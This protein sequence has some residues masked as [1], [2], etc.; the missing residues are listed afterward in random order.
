M[1]RNYV[2]N[3]ANMKVILQ[4]TQTFLYGKLLNHFKKI[5]GLFAVYLG[6]VP[7]FDL[8]TIQH[9]GK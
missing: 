5:I 1:R 4:S 7:A 3:G 2:I 8:C 9:T 6:S